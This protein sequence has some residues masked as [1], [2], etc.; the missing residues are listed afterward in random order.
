MSRFGTEGTLV[1]ASGDTLTAPASITLSPGQM[2][3]WPMDESYETDSVTHT[4]K[5]GRKLQYQNYR[6]IKYELAWTDLDESKKNE[7]GTMF[8][9]LPILAI[10]TT[11]FPTLGTFKTEPDSWSASETRFGIYDVAFT[12]VG[13]SSL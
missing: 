5:T 10:N 13:T 4:T 12:V 3:Q 7:I 2:P 11:N 9:S 8:N 6:L 1:W